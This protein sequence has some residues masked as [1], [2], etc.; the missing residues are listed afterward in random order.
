[1]IHFQHS[2]DPSNFAQELENLQFHFQYLTFS[3]HYKINLLP[4]HFT[5]TVFNLNSRN[6]SKF[7]IEFAQTPRIL[8]DLI[9]FQ[10]YFS[11]V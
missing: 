9:G 11:V 6:T 1:M 5:N 3:T 7:V 2:P 10:F 4:Q 8:I